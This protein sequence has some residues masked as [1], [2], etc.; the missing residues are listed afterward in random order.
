MEY[1]MFCVPWFDG[2]SGHRY[3][4][5]NTKMKVLLHEHEYDVWKFVFTGYTTT[6]KLKIATKK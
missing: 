6:K 2:K 4:M 1:A 3:E 5:W